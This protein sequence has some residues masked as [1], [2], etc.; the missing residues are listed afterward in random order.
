MAY[1]EKL[2]LRLREQ[3]AGMPT[4]TEKKMFGGVCHLLL[5]HM[6]CGV[7]K[8]SLIL[9]L[10]EETARVALQEPGVRVFDVTGKPMKGWVMVAPEAIGDD[11]ILALRLER[12]FAFNATLPPK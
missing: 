4:W 3:F 7:W 5:G 1:N 12:A 8:D 11:D 2:N 6:V 9:R 10:G